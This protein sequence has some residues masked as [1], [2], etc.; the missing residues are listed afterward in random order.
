MLLPALF[1]AAG[2]QF[3]FFYRAVMVLKHAELAL[4]RMNFAVLL[5]H[6]IVF[7]WCRYTT[8]TD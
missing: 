7:G 6:C 5:E 1:S 2:I 8:I 4:L 3:G